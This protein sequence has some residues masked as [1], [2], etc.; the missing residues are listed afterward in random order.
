MTYE[1][2]GEI[3]GGH[4]SSLETNDEILQGFLFFGLFH[5][6]THFYQ[7]SDV[8]LTFGGSAIAKTTIFSL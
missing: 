7:R 3:C 2:I 8:F 4:F 5:A 6:P 1:S